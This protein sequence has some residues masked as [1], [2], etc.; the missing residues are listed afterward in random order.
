MFTSR[1]QYEK[2][3]R[4]REPST[5]YAPNVITVEITVS[6][7]NA[8]KFVKIYIEKTRLTASPCS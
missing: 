4:C 7:K 8:S 1:S 5:T 3:D 6:Q 2:I